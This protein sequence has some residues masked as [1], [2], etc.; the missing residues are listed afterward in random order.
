MVKIFVSPGPDEKDGA[1]LLPRDL[2][3]EA[4]PVFRAALDGEDWLEKDDQSMTLRDVDPEI[5][6]ILVYYLEHKGYVPPLR[7]LGT[8]GES[9]VKCGKL[10][11][12]AD[13]FNMPPLQNIISRLM[14][15]WIRDMGLDELEGFMHLVYGRDSEHPEGERGILGKMLRFKFYYSQKEDLENCGYEIIPEM[16]KALIDTHPTFDK[17]HREM[18]EALKDDHEIFK[19]S[20]SYDWHQLEAILKVGQV[21]GIGTPET[22]NALMEFGK[23][24]GDCNLANDNSGRWWL[25]G[26][27]RPG[28]PVGVMLG[29]AGLVRRRRPHRGNLGTLNK[30]PFLHSPED[31]DRTLYVN[32]LARSLSRSQLTGG[33]LFLGTSYES[34]FFYLESRYPTLP[35]PDNYYDV[36]W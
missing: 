1:F 20:R 14:Q 25:S 2:A 32:I 21:F 12:L 28:L 7:T 15:W 36:L 3:I 11:M 34:L 27:R 19:G 18:A 33:I 24:L 5:F 16:M 8:P 13:L 31:Y 23:R 6:E 35:T 30:F 9:L 29:P 22:R 26:S 4:S 10:W 17:Y